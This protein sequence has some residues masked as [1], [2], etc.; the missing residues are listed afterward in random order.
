MFKTEQ[1]AE[2]V[3]LYLGD[4]REVIPTL[5]PVNAVITDPPYGIEDIVGNYSRFQNDNT[6]HHILND[7]DLSCMVQSF[8]LIKKQFNNIWVA[9]FYSP[10]I[11]REFFSVTMDMDY[12]GEIVWDKKILGLGNDIRYQ[13][14][15]IGVFKIGEPERVNQTSSVITYLR[16]GAEKSRHPHEKPTQVMHK[17]CSIFPGKVILDPYMGTGTTGA[18]AIQLNR[19]FIGIELDENYFD[20]SVKK[21]SAALKQP[22]PFWE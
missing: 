22:T 8:A 20:L 6:D 5:G 4:C 19:G 17:L 10:R 1:L 14:E 15:N 12:Y 16:V 18:A 21:V 9:A 7:K 11:S 3:T 2:N 13:H